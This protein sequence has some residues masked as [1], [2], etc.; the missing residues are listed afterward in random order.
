MPTMMTMMTTW[1]AAVLC[2]H[3][4]LT[5]APCASPCGSPYGS[6]VWIKSL[7]AQL[8]ENPSGEAPA[9]VSLADDVEMEEGC[10]LEVNPSDDAANDGSDGDDLCILEENPDGLAQ[11]ASAEIDSDEDDCVLEA[12]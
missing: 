11:K 5:A 4:A 9:A 3:R 8:E 10:V 2:V 7:G 6:P 12:N 1:R